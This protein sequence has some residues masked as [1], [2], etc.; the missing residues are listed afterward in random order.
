MSFEHLF[1][2]GKHLVVETY[3]F[4]K[5]CNSVKRKATL[6][7]LARFLISDPIVLDAARRSQC[8]P[9]RSMT[10]YKH[11]IKRMLDFFGVP[12][13]SNKPYCH[14]SDDE[15]ETARRVIRSTLT[16]FTFNAPYT[17]EEI[18]NNKERLS[19]LLE[20]ALNEPGRRTPNSILRH[21]RD[22]EEFN[23]FK[24]KDLFF[25]LPELN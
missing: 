10:K 3:T 1:A 21:L 15:E 24:A 5:T 12:F 4:A 19:Q 8:D 7:K 23:M 22:T 20:L 11:W 25:I 18:D 14:Y 16:V 6:Y 2:F 17:L 13:H 9:E